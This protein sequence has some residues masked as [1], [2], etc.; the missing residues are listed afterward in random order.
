M[1]DSMNDRSL[2]RR[3]IGVGV[4]AALVVLVLVVIAALGGF[5]ARRSATLPMPLGTEIDTGMMIYLPESAT[6]TFLAESSK[7][8]WEVVIS[9]QVRNPQAEALEPFVDMASNIVGVDPRT[10]L[11]A[12]GPSYSLFWDA[13]GEGFEYANRSLVPPD[14]DWMH[15]RLRVRHDESFDPGDTYL[16]ALRPMQFRATAHYGYS[17]AKSWAA[18]RFSRIYTV[19]VPLTRLPDRDY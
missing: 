9:L 14:S 2:R 8:P 10:R 11:I 18:A 17:E 5:Q 15:M 19:E 3:R 4:A 1:S 7:N 16:V 6:V 12:V 13:P